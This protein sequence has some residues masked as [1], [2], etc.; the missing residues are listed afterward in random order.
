[1]IRSIGVR[2]AI[3]VALP[4]GLL[5]LTLLLVFAPESSARA[6]ASWLPALFIPIAVAALTWCVVR[7][8]LGRELMRIGHAFGEAAAGNQSLRLPESG[9]EIAP[10]ARAFNDMQAR[11][12]RSFTRAHDALEFQAMHD[13]LT[14]LP[15]RALLMDRLAQAIRTA[16][17][18]HHCLALMLADLD[19]FKEINDTLGH[20]V[21]DAVLQKAAERM[22]RVVRD[23]DTVARLGGDEFAFLLPTANDAQ[24]GRIAT[25][26]LR[27]FEEPF[28]VEGRTLTAGMSIGISVFPQ[29]GADGPTLLRRADVAMYE[30]KRAH[31]GQALYE[32]EYDLHSERH[33]A[34]R[35]ELRT[36]LAENQLMLCFQPVL[37]LASGEVSGVE[38]LAR[39]RHPRRGVLHPNDFIPLAERTGLIRDLTLW[40]IANAAEQCRIWSGLGLELRVAVNLSAHNLHDPELPRIVDRIVAGDGS[41]SDSSV[42]LR[43]EITETAVMPGSSRAFEVLNRLSAQGV[44]I[45]IDDFGTG[46]SSLAYLK[47][48]PVDELKI[49]RS[50]VT[51]MVHDSDDAVIVRST[52]D[53]AHNIG[54]RVV[55][56]GVEDEATRELLAAMHCDAV[57]GYHIGRPMEARELVAWLRDRRA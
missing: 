54:L 18:G 57:Q 47:R 33:L 29:H 38:A 22:R 51:A 13:A 39:W 20:P 10:L 42:R 43:L 9:G 12:E 5:V 14:E 17:R 41:Q 21:G 31:R 15:N 48:L 37:D 4:T 35:N 23:S 7:A 49:D 1:M 16:Q 24:A 45:S 28:E 40:V 50:F 52:I 19:H 32:R 27:A 56:E 25:K 8:V 30:A 11:V 36:A 46:Y 53:L 44:H 6:P 2:V 26:L 55:A 34:F 3:M